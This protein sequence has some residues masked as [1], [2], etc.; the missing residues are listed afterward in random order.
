[1]KIT[2]ERSGGFAGLSNTFSADETTLTASEK[3]QIENLLR[4]SK[5]FK[6]TSKVKNSADDESD[7]KGA[8]DYFVY[9]ITIENDDGKVSTVEVNDMTMDSQLRSV[10]KTVEE[11]Q[12]EEL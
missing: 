6:S 5:F 12:K 3:Q 11:K 2:V 1:M 4:N 10:V 7:S 9:R 8:A